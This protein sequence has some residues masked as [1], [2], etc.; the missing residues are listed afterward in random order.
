MVASGPS[1][2][3]LP[4]HS[5]VGGEEEP[6]ISN[7]SALSVVSLLLGLAAPLSLAAP[8]LWAIPLFGAAVAI[9]TMRR[10]ATS[11]GTL[12]GRRAAVI[13]LALSVASLCAAA[14]HSITS[15]QILSH[16]ARSTALEWFSLVTSGDIPAAF[17]YTADSTRGPGPPP[18]PG[19]PP[20]TE[21]PRDP[22]AV[23]RDHPLIQYLASLGKD[24][25]TRF[26][27]DLEFTGDVNG[28]VQIK[29]QFFVS[30][31]PGGT[32]P[33]KTVHVT[34]YRSRPTGFL[35]GKWQVSTYGSEDL[36]ATSHDE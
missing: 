19:T 34:M 7:I 11:D 2:A 21:P 20:S 28:E 3:T 26:D 29:E 14:S 23:F 10:I 27:Q 32:Q 25:Q 22:V 1:T 18:P 16:Q 35:A 30:P 33:A 15:E 4:A 17:Q 13:G 36:P 9:V 8:L 12:I 24:S 6:A 5:V 31:A